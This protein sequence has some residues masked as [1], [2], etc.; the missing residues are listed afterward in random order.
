M[1]YLVCCGPTLTL[2]IVTLIFMVANQGV[3]HLYTHICAYPRDS[4]REARGWIGW[5]LGRGLSIRLS[6]Y[7]IHNS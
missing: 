1:A 5:R 3:A 2:G 4:V 6:R 7:P